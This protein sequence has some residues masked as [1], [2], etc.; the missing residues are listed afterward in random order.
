MPYRG[1]APITQ[2]L[3]AGQ[4]DMSCPAA[5]PTLP[6]LRA[7]PIKAFAVPAENRWFAAPE[8]P[9]I[10]EAG[11]PGLYVPSWHGVW[12]PK[13]TPKDV[14][15]TLNAAVAEA[16]ADSNV[17]AT[18]DRSWAGD[19]AARIVVSRCAAA[20]HK[21]ELDKWWPIMKSANIRAE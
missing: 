19:R 21:A 1:S 8:V 6:Q 7:G 2:N 14:I 13:G 20:Y 18:P 9:T 16:L 4:I 10:D 15:A 12:V 17:R 5:G 3:V 11:V